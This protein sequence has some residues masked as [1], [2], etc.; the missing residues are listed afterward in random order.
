LTK[1]LRVKLADPNL[2]IG[3]GIY[4]LTKDE[5]RENEIS[6]DIPH[7]KLFFIGED[8][9]LYPESVKG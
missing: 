4:V 6:T 1:G 9:C 7:I 8:I 2:S 3:S 5:L